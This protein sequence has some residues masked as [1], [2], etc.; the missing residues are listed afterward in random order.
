M[1]DGATRV[2]SSKAWL[3][4]LDLEE[5]KEVNLRMSDGSFATMIWIPGLLCLHRHAC[6]FWRWQ[7]MDCKVSVSR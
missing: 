1:R 3:A 7:P 2:N 5:P 6:Q 4:P